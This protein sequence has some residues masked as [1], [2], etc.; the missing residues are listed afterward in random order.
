MLFPSVCSQ[1]WL[2][3]TVDSMVRGYTPSTSFTV[4]RWDAP[5]DP[6]RVGFLRFCWSVF[7]LASCCSGSAAVC[8]ARSLSALL[9][10][11]SLHRSL[12]LLF[13]FPCARG[14]SELTHNSKVSIS[15]IIH[16]GL[17]VTTVIAC[18][19]NELSVQ[20]TREEEESRAWNMMM[21]RSHTGTY[22]TVSSSSP[23]WSVGWT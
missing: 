17:S 2:R 10:G 14:T 15:T 8:R 9:C 3:Q 21:T 6:A 7:G 5:F 13:F 12:L 4:P 11:T 22:T 18:L 20:Q 19:S 23:I 16:T 1:S